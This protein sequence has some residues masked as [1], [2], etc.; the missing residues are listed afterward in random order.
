MNRLTTVLIVI[1][2]LVTAGSLVIV[3]SVRFG[4]G[5]GEAVSIGAAL[6]TAFGLMHLHMERRRDRAWVEQRM[7]EVSAAASDGN[8]EVGQVAARVNRLEREIAPRVRRE[9]EPLAAEVEVLGHLMKQ[10]AETVA[11][12]EI[13][14]DRRIE[15]VAKAAAKPRLVAPEPAAVPPPVRPAERFTA[16]ARRSRSIRRAWS[17]R[18][19]RRASPPPSSARSR[20]RCA[21]SGS[22]C[23]SSRSSRSPS[24][25]CATTR[26]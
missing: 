25:R 1:A 22:S 5:V 11:D 15:E 20:P 23:I 9:T 8:T 7:T 19:R 12:L 13:R 6:L 4:L 18:R 3:L 16:E 17:R 26:F 2:M 14:T 24:A 10:I 21:P